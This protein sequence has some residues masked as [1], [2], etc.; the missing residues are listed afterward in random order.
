MVSAN[1]WAEFSNLF[2]NIEL[3]QIKGPHFVLQSS[4]EDS[5][6]KASEAVGFFDTTLIKPNAN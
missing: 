6:R 3:D 4:P 2:E 1:K 5:A